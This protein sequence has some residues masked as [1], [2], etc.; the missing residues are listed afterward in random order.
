MRTPASSNRLSR[1]HS[2]H[3][4]FSHFSIL[5]PLA[6]PGSAAEWLAAMG[7]GGLAPQIQEV[8]RERKGS[9]DQR[10]SGGNFF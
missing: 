3:T 10:G 1:A 8:I 6:G 9:V 7:Q 2:M 4:F 5:S